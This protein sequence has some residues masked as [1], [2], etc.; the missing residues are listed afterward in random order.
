MK[1]DPMIKVHYPHVHKDVDRHGNVRVYFWRKG[2]R[3]IRIREAP[4][5]KEF[6]ETY[7]ALLA[8]S[9]AGALSR[10]E[11]GIKPGTYRW[12][13]VQYFGSAEFKRLD[14][15]SQRTRRGILEHTLREPIASNAVET[16]ADFPLARMTPKAVRVLRDR[17]LGLPGSADNRVK[18]IRRLFAWAL[19]NELVSFNPAREV[20]YVSNATLGHHSWTKDEVDQYEQRHP[21]G[22]KARLALALLMWT[23]VRRSDVVL[24]GKQH[25]RDGWL[26]F[27]QQKNRN[28]RPVTI[29]IPV[30]EA[31]RDALDQSPTGDLTFLV[32]EYGRPFSGDGFGNWFRDRC[33]EAG[34]ERCSAHGLRKA[35]AAIAAENGATT[36]QL[37]SI[38]GWLT[39]REA[40][41]Y[42]QAAE[43]RRLAGEATTLLM[44]PKK[45]T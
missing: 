42:T 37:M 20:R 13:C 25:I 27:T 5:T 41:R 26:K 45:R 2:Q 38:F 14:S 4:G 33:R 6:S 28:R 11:E 35:G 7:H 31:L 21:V 23:G 8:Q 15:R 12:L 16:F 22:S 44:R 40:E 9:D 1:S 19:E 43:R 17:K 30:L 10:G 29:E 39:M 18:A 24:L 32:T 34:L 36:H 3:K